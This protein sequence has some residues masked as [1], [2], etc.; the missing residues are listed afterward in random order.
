MSEM[1]LK[2][3][4]IALTLT[5]IVTLLAP[6]DTKADMLDEPACT[7]LKAEQARLAAA[8]LKTEML[9][10]PDWAKANLPQSRLQ[11]IKHLMEVEEQINFRCPLPPPPK[12]PQP[13]ATAADAE[14]KGEP[15]VTKKKKGKKQ[16]DEAVFEIPQIDFPTPDAD[17]AAAKPKKA[18]AK[19]KKKESAND[20]Y[21]PPP[22]QGNA[23]VDGEARPVPQPPA[24]P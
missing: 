6:R 21:V 13:A 1:V 2:R 16:R 20:A 8:G 19:T 18:K 11:E 14:A 7:A 23:F 10:G 22:S 9:H 15:K 3:A 4:P 5:L 24:Q 17:P 12:P